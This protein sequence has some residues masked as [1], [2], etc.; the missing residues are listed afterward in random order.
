MDK[1][2]VISVKTIFYAILMVLGVFVVFR[3]GRIIGYVLMS[4]LITISFEHTIKFFTR[5]T[6]FNK[7][8]SRPLSV[9][10][11]YLLVFLTLSLAIT[12]GLDP[13]ITQS[14]KLIQTLSRHPEIISLGPDIKFSTSDIVQNLVNRSGGVFNTA[15]SFF[16]NVAALFSILI[17]SIYM[18]LDWENIKERFM[19]FIKEKDKDKV[20]KAI[21]NIED[22]VGLWLKGQLILMIAIG[23]LSYFGL[24]LVGV[25][26]PL[27]LALISGIFEIVPIIGPIISAVVAALVAVIDSPIKALLIVGVFALIQQTEGN[28]LVPKVMQKVSGFS[29]IIILIALLI[30]SNLFGLIG[31]VIAVPVLMIGAIIVRTILDL[32][33]KK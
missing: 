3:L 7:K 23:V 21:K 25:Q 1:N 31:A 5:Q 24:L 4:L 19:I 17:L 2:I 13:I 15:K 14:Q 30:G 8:V 20:K 18:S 16:N 9:L 26:F 10:V 22:N 33:E 11:T 27:A 28:I 32:E 6:L 12:L 29:P